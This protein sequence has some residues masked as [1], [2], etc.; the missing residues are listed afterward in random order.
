MNSTRGLL[1]AICLATPASVALAQSVI[2]PVEGGAPPAATS[3]RRAGSTNAPAPASTSPSSPFTWAGLSFAPHVLYRL[4]YTDGL[5]TQPGQPLTTYVQNVAPGI[6]IQAEDRWLFDY[7]PTWK[8]YSNRKFR[9]TLDHSVLLNGQF[10]WKTWPVFLS[11]TYVDSSEVTI[12]AARE[13]RQQTASTTVT[14][15]HPFSQQ[16]ALQLDGTQ[17]LRFRESANDVFT[18]SGTAWLNDQ[19]A[20]TLQ[21][22]AGASGGYMHIY[23]SPDIRNMGP[24]ARI[25]WQPAPTITFDV[26]CGLQRLSFESG[27]R[28]ALNTVIYH[29]A[30]EYRPFAET[31]ISLTAAR[32]VTP[33]I[34]TNDLTRSESLGVALRQRVFG[35]FQATLGYNEGR[36]HYI[37]TRTSISRETTVVP[38]TDADGNIIGYQ[39]TTT[40]T[41]TIVFTDRNDVV[42]AVN[43]RLATTWLKRGTVAIAYYRS[44][45]HSNA[46]GYGFITHQIAC[47][48][49]WR[50]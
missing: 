21:V 41:P 37:I 16:Y 50:Y 27:G 19:L 23:H 2:P 17:D 18:W 39:T 30:V 10:P 12:E 7:T 26:E 44:Q 4:L 22:G 15:V 1:L 36:S 13:L 6:S 49:T 38:V 40:T 45:N 34:F 5:L 8:F 32:A 9:D 35:H 47:D 31:R 43:L 28:S 29:G 46:P 14:T 24:T 20:P 33:S 25:M 3:P 11:Q 42:R 48:V